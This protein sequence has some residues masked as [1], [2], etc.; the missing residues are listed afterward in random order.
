MKSEIYTIHRLVK[1]EDL[2]HHGT[3]YAG[4]TA[5]WFVE[6]GFIAASSLLTPASTVCLQIHGMTFSRPVHLGE[7]AFFQSRVV[8]SG[9]SKLVSYV[10]M[11]AAGE[12]VVEGFI[13]FV[14]VDAEGKVL[15]HE[16]NIIPETE[17]ELA[18]YQRAE[19]LFK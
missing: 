5:E 7:I 10:N 19:N 12:L 1:H 14:H 16:I 13:T 18:L 11:K 6:A 15:P 3:L 2:N 17:E 4:R 9:R 8:Y